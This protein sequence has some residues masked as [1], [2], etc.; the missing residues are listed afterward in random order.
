MT[1]DTT[2]NKVFLAYENTTEALW[3]GTIGTVTAGTNSISFTGTA[4]I[5][6]ASATGNDYGEVSYNSDAN[7]I[8]FFYRDDDNSD[9][10]TYK[11]ITPGA[12]SFS[13][14]DGAAISSADNRFVGG[15]S[16]FGSGKGTLLPTFDSA[17][18]NK[19]SYA[20]AFFGTTTA[21]NLD[22]GNYLGI[23]AEAISDTATGKINV[24]GGTSTGHSSLTIG[25]H[26]FTNGAGAIGLVGNTLGE[27]YLGKAI[28][29]TEIQ[30][31]ENEG[32]LYGTA[33]GA[34]TAGKPIF[35]EADGDFLMP[36]SNT[37][38]YTYSIGSDTEILNGSS[39][40]NQSTTYAANVDRFVVAFLNADSSN[41]PTV[42][43]VSVGSNNAVAV[44]ATEEINTS[45]YAH[46]N[47]RVEYDV[48]NEKVLYVYQSGATSNDLRCKVLTIGASSIS[49]GSEVVIDDSNSTASDI[50]VAYDT[51]NSKFVVYTRDQSNSNYPTAYVGSISGTTP[52]FGTAQVVQSEGATNVYDVGF[53]GDKFLF[54][55]KDSSTSD[56]QAIAASLS[57]T[58][59][60][61]GTKFEFED[62]N[63]DISANQ[64]HLT[65]VSPANL[66]VQG[67]NHQ[68]GGSPHILLALKVASDNSITKGYETGA[69]GSASTNVVYGYN[70][71]ASPKKIDTLTVP[72][73]YRNGSNDIKYN[74]YVLEEASGEN[75]GYKI[76]KGTEVALTLSSASFTSIAQAGAAQNY[77]MLA[78]YEDSG[79]DINGY[80]IHPAGSATTTTFP[81][82]GKGFIGIATK[83]VANDAQVEVATTGQIDAQQS[84]LTA[85]ETYYAQSDGS[86]GTSADSLGSVVVGKALSATKL[87]IE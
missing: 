39:S 19:L 13:V 22:N 1:Y 79:N 45:A 32:Y 33:E 21:S 48:T 70:N 64:D 5:W 63:I 36:T 57:G 67:Y 73:I 24:I 58:T 9:Y 51:T 44:T 83:T 3:K 81:T 60:S 4:T 41:R 86:L 14:A 29:A 23:A 59:L 15:T 80:G 56:G 75:I 82:S 72:I 76:T 35:V 17:D 11:T 54:T 61:F 77:K 30:L 16:S 85:A 25:N 62:D 68:G 37:T 34:V 55:Y 26:Y 6:N 18:S 31:L 71:G 40:Q 53:G 2:N 47:A 50:N 66:F 43:V 74:E 38:T 20:T 52:S 28:S 7:K 49:A 10:T 84:G 8:L 42:K 46:E 87:L 12:S 78:T 65:Y 69:S 27:Q